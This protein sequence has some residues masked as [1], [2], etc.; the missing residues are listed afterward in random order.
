MPAT[1]LV[2]QL[3]R[4]GLLARLA[5]LQPRE[6]RLALGAGVI[7]G[8]W[9]A[10]SW[11][12]QPLWDRTQEVALHVERQQE[13]LA[14]LNRVLDQARGRPADD[15]SRAQWLLS[16]GAD[17]A[18][19][20]ALLSDIEALSRTAR[21]QLNLK[22]RPVKPDGR[23]DRFDVEMDVEGS[24]AQLLAFVDALLR[25]PSLVTVERLRLSS[26]ATKEQ[27]L[28]ATL[29]IQQVSLHNR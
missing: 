28:R 17:E 7:I 9:L 2:R 29:V 4:S 11:L 10:V 19:R 6:R 24:Q 21:V 25:L 26:V 12:V 3:Q 8:C 15:R 13:R 18:G 23:L 5:A 20:R 22:P 27:W 1:S 14:A 16:S